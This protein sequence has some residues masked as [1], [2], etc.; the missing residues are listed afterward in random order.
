[1]KLDRAVRQNRR[2]KKNMNNLKTKAFGG[3]LAVL[4]AMGV[5]LFLAAGTL[6]YWQAWVFLAVFG[7]AGL[8]I[9][10]YLMKEDPQLLERRMSG[11]PTAEKRISQKIIMSISSLGFAALLVVPGLDHRFGWSSVPPYVI[12]TGDVLFVVGWIII[13]FVFKENTFTS[14]TIEVAADQ[15]VIST[16]PYA[17]VR[18]P[19]Y[20][21]SLLY[22]LAMPIALGSWWGLLVILLM[23]PV[24]LW[25]IFDEENLLKKDLAGYT[26]Y[27][28]KVRYRLVPYLW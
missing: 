7:V 25:R 22:M 6:N 17:I 10:V 15:H 28:Q 23:M 18:H 26:Q 8:A 4:I 20:S 1:V 5:L 2:E 11:G 19:M 27:T 9:I 21:G 16:G 12:I 24:N 3:V 13:F 14:S